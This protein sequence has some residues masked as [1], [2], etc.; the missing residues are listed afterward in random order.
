[1]KKRADGLY[2]KKIV[3]GHKPDGTPIVKVVYGKTQKEVNEKAYNLKGGRVHT[4]C[5]F[6]VVA[7]EMLEEK[8]KT[9]GANT[10][11]RYCET[12]CHF[13][14]LFDADI[15]DITASDLNSLIRD[16]YSEGYSKSTLRKIRAFYSL[17][18]KY[19]IEKGLD[20]TD[21]TNV[22]TI[23]KNAPETKRHGISDDEIAV[24][25]NNV[26]RE[27]GLYAFVMMYTGLRRGELCA[28]TWDDIDFNDGVIRV[29][30]SV[31]FISNRPHIKQPKTTAG[32]R[33]VPILNKLYTPLKSAY[34]NKLDTDI[35]VFGGEGPYS[36]TMIKRRWAKYIKSA[37]LNITQHQLR[38]TYATL[39]YRSGVDAK[40]AQNLLG[41][42]DVQ[43]TLNIYTDIANDVKNI[44]VEKLNRFLD[45]GAANM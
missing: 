24:I 19:A 22:I 15:W 9:V 18:A 1:M 21:Y 36:D 35:Y 38:H 45:S 7:E 42:A 11:K 20:I 23:P 6:K 12:L 10:Y 2:Q 44:S 8:K 28:L 31:E 30:K 41:H 33:Y 26:N 5:R 32:I 29:N 37:G 27:F 34:S 14:P 39:L 43:T 4:S 13:K 3:T 40:T 17:V 16:K 25:E